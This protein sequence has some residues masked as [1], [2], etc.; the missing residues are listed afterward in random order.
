MPLAASMT[1]GRPT[2]LYK[3]PVKQQKVGTDTIWV[4]LKL[5]NDEGLPCLNGSTQVD[6]LQQVT[7][8]KTVNRRET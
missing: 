7:G 5:G 2:I 8:Q 1:V 4:C 3:Q 6:D